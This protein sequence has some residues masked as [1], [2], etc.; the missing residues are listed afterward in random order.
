M[1]LYI[2]N[3]HCDW[4]ESE[5]RPDLIDF[6]SLQ[7]GS[8]H[9]ATWQSA[10]YGFADSKSLRQ[11]RK[12]FGHKPLPVVG[13]RVKKRWGYNCGQLLSSRNTFILNNDIFIAMWGSAVMNQD[14]GKVCFL[15]VV[16]KPHI[17]QKSRS[18]VKMVFSHWHWCV[19]LHIFSKLNLDHL[20]NLTSIETML[21]NSE[22][23]ANA[24]IFIFEALCGEH[25]LTLL[26]PK[27]C[28]VLWNE[29]CHSE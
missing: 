15:S 26:F 12:K 3:L 22:I 16:W 8:G 11:L 13:A 14:E 4:S 24:I 10:V 23:W 5:L 7:G 17:S 21:P 27:W 29:T 9:D 6:L 19:F 28:V 1:N 25:L 18:W 20:K 2:P